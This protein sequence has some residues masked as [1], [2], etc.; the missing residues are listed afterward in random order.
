MA[1]FP[2]ANRL[3]RPEE[4]RRV[5]ERGRHRRLQI[6]GLTLRV[7]EN[8]LP[9]ARL[10][11]AISKRSLK[12]A[13]QRNRVKRLVR[14][15][16]RHSFSDLPAVDIVMMSQSELASM[17]NAAILQQLEV[18]WQRVRQLYGASANKT[19]PS[20]HHAPSNRKPD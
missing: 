17:D 4:F 1:S 9:H 14:E 8:T 10:G 16:F 7:R 19:Q 11:L 2:R 13:V 18:S 15:S 12:L 20:G 5:F 6:T 3:T